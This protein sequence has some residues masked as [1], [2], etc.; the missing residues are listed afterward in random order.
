MVCRDRL[1]ILG[2][3]GCNSMDVHGVFVSAFSCGLK[4]GFPS[5]DRS[6]RQSL[7]PTETLSS[8]PFVIIDMGPILTKR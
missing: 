5:I 4:S 6:K 3:S 7:G 1:G 8:V 2:T